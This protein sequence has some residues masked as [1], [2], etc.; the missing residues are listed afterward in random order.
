MYLTLQYATLLYSFPSA[1]PCVVCSIHENDISSKDSNFCK[2]NM[3]LA[4]LRFKAFVFFEIKNKEISHTLYGL[5]LMFVNK[6]K[7]DFI[8]ITKISKSICTLGPFFLA[9]KAHASLNTEESYLAFLLRRE[10]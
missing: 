6:M 3:I 4:A 10:R 7:E 2:E 5:Y 9:F 1:Q 8:P